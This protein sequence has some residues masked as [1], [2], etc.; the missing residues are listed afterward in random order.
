MKFLVASRDEAVCGVL[1]REPYVV[2]SISDPGSRQPKVKISGLC[3]EVLHLRFHDAEPTEGFELPSTIRL[4]TPADA[5]VTWNLIRRW[6]E[7]IE[8]VLVHCH[9]GMSRSP[10]VAAAICRA[11]GQNDSRFFREYQPNMYVYGLIL[12]AAGMDTDR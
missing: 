10:A 11:L 5:L 9:A 12:Q 2:I 8:T 1:V 3:R 7:E 6:Q 4:M